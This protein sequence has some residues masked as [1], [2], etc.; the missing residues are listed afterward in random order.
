MAT[1][2]KSK[3]HFALFNSMVRSVVT[4][5]AEIW[6]LGHLDDIDNLQHYFVKKLLRLPN[7]TPGFFLNLDFR[8]KQIRID[9]VRSA[10]KLWAKC[11]QQNESN[12]LLN[13]YSDM[14]EEL[15]AKQ[16]CNWSSQLHLILKDYL[17]EGLWNLAGLRSA[18]NQSE[19][20][21]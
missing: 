19:R 10:L 21:L 8:L 14:W 9:I 2:G 18:P 15:P 6:G 5:G 17:P 12:Q 7:N 1:N 20:I 4:Y 11:L 16:K 13:C 3:T